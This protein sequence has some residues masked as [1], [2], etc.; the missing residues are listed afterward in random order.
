MSART[1]N[2]LR[3][4]ISVLLRREKRRPWLRKQVLLSTALHSVSII[5][6]TVRILLLLLLLIAF[7]D[8]LGMICRTLVNHYSMQQCVIFP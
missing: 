2:Y 5:L 8:P 6:L 4:Q 3:K 7:Y 1:L